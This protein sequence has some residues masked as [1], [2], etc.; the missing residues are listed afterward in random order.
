MT[1]RLT[2]LAHDAV[3]RVLEPGDLAVDATAGNGYDTVLLAAAVGPSGCVIAFDAQ[4]EAI[5]ATRERL[6]SSG[7]D[8]CVRLVEG[9]HSTLAE[10]LPPG[11][12]LRAAMF[13]LGYLPGSDKQFIT[14]SETTLPALATC[15]ERVG[16]GGVISVMAYRGHA[17]GEAEAAAVAAAFGELAES[18]FS[19]D[20]HDAP[21]TGPVL[22][23][24]SRKS[25]VASPGRVGQAS[26]ARRR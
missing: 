7:C 15:L 19:I 14:R 13:N 18:E 8:K 6:L 11:A 24:V 4:P 1:R 17:G 20:R 23:L 16:P 26:S 2:E 22:W 5:V 10:A 12:E 3:R 9:C 25:A 21:G